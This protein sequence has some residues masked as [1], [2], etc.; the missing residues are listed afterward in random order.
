MKP[1]TNLNPEEALARVLEGVVP[2]AGEEVPL[3]D[4]LYRV[5][6]HPLTA[7]LEDPRF[8][9]AAVDGIAIR[10]DDP[11]REF[12]I[13]ATIA[14]G[15]APAVTLQ[16]GEAV[17]IMTGAP[18]PD[19][20]GRIVMFEHCTFSE[21]GPADSGG[22]LVRAQIIHDGTAPN[23]AWQGENITVGAP[24]LPRRRLLPQDIGILAAQGYATLEVH[25]PVR[26]AV[27]A[28]GDE[29]VPAGEPLGPASIHDS[30]SPQLTAYARSAH[31]QAVNLGIAGDTRE[32]IS[33]RIQQELHT[34]DIM[35]LSGGVSM[36]DL[37]Y[38]P[39][40]LEELGAEIV[41]HGLALK[42]GRPT[43][44][45]VYRNGNHTTRIFGLP[46]NPVS[47][48]VQFELLIRPLMAALEGDPWTPREGVFPLAQEYRRRNTERHEYV[49]G[50]LQ[51][52][53]V[54]PVGY[55]GSG[56]L[57]ALSEA[58]LIFRIDRGVPEK[59]AGEEVHVRFLR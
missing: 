33:A 6:V 25:R 31:G 46:G 10:A 14:A 56:H 20:A 8:N 47:T 40:V 51:N 19:D 1:H 12:R 49:P 48:A 58:T 36:G 54:V 23:I 28:T 39:Q 17:R 7:R 57:T 2:T 4:A 15:D 30:N 35:I 44:F 11:S 34:A 13:T 38:V 5:P 43:L 22:P 53:K 3:A 42:P 32:T 29:I 55:M 26:V 59:R 18:V 37:D 21:E 9:K 24:L 41:F 27:I 52:G 16:H 50:W 45:A